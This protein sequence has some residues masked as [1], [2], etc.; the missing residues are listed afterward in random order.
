MKNSRS[1]P[2]KNQ[3]TQSKVGYRTKHRI[4]N[5]RISNGW[6]TLKEMLKIL[7]DHG[8][9]VRMTLRFHLTA[10]RMA[11]I[12]LLFSISW[13]VIRR[14]ERKSNWLT[15]HVP[16]NKTKQHWKPLLEPPSLLGNRFH[17]PWKIFSTPSILLALPP[18][19]TCWNI[20]LFIT[21]S[22]IT[23][24]KDLSNLQTQTLLKRLAKEVSYYIIHSHPIV[25]N[26]YSIN[27]IIIVSSCFRMRM[28]FDERALLSWVIR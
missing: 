23:L 21:Y 10:F 11:K 16:I 13:I 3:T 1:L 20:F 5:R 14:Q 6:E 15:L 17:I 25:I 24:A 19:Y 7:S 8:M 2:P 27:F 26:L 12:F 9:Q 4:H 22:S 18:S 28:F